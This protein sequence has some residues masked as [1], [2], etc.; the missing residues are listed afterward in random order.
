MSMGIPCVRNASIPFSLLTKK[1][2]VPYVECL[3][4]YGK[5]AEGV[6]LKKTCLL[7]A[8]TDS[9]MRTDSAMQ[10]TRSSSQDEKMLGGVL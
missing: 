9:T 6:L 5:S 10:C 3:W 4:G 1:H 8:F 7:R 2:P